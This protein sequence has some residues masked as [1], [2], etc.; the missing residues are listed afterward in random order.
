MTFQKYVRHISTKLA[1]NHLSQAPCDF[2]DILSTFDFLHFYS[3]KFFE[4]FFVLVQYSCL[5]VTL[6]V[7]ISETFNPLKLNL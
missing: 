5:F 7:N 1:Y 3:V 6:E 2:H 4:F